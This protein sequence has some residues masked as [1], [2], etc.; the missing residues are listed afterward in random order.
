LDLGKV[1]E[2]TLPYR[3][4]VVSASVAAGETHHQEGN[5]ASS[6]YSIIT[7]A[8]RHCRPVV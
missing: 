2:N 4:F 3:F 1:I 7:G 5:T 6:H 8:I